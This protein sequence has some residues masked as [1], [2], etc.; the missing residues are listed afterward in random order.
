LVNNATGR[1]LVRFR[2]WETMGQNN[3]VSP[4]N[5]LEGKLKTNLGPVMV[6]HTYNPSYSGSRN[7]SIMIQGQPRQKGRDPT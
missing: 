7:R 4:T 3:S 6:I 2:L 1:Q 5:N